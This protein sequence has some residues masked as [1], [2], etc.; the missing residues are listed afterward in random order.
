MPFDAE[1]DFVYRVIKETVEQHDL[2]CLRADERLIS[3]PVMEDVKSQIAKA[4]V[5]VV[6]FTNKNPNVYFEAGLADAWKKKWIVLAQSP[7]DLTFDVRHIRTIIYSH[8]M[9]AD[10]TLKQSLEK[11]LKETMGTVG[12]ANK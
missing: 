1:L 4:D 9:G 11:A 5:V 6:D 10:V 12:G 3:E 7:T 2:D 8:K